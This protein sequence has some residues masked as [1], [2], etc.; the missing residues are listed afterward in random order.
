LTRDKLGIVLTPT[1]P[2]GV[3]GVDV[4]SVTLRSWFELAS[5][6]LAAAGLAGCRAIGTED[7]VLTTAKGLSCGVERWSVKTGSDP[8]VALVSLAPND[9]AILTLVA[10]PRPGSL[11]ANRRV[12]PF[13]LATYR[14]RDVTLTRYKL[15]TDSDYHLVISDGV[16]TMIAEIPAPDCVD[17]ASP[18]L[19][20]IRIARAAFD[21]NFVATTVFQ[22]TNTIA[23]V[24]GV[25]FFDFFH[26][27]TG[28]APNA[29]ELHA[30]TGICFAAGCQTQ[31]ADGGVSSDGGVPDAG[32][33]RPDGVNA[34]GS[35]GCG[36][37]STGNAR[38]IVPLLSLP[39]LWQIRRRSRPA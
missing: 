21:A 4:S 7:D 33:P 35:S 22:T 8:D 10:F 34:F 38:G 23:T 19:P 30:V 32:R 12:A 16:N 25:G 14:V 27:Q 18:L 1:T 2:F 5:F 15:E 20:G 11:P 13:E 9:T 36:C 39:L 24:E 17:A 31:V 26:G 37:G 3:S 6:V 29:F 28:V